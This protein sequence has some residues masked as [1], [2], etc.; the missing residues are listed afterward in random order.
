MQIRPS[1]RIGGCR[2]T[3]ESITRKAKTF[4]LNSLGVCLLVQGESM[5]IHFAD[6]A[7]IGHLKDYHQMRRNHLKS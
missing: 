6:V 5:S 1:N 3:R 4:T 7:K 2:R